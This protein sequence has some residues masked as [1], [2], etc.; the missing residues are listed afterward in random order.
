MHFTLMHF[1]F[2]VVQFELIKKNVV[3][4][5]ARVILQS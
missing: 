1:S 4:F 2:Y 5:D 3:Q